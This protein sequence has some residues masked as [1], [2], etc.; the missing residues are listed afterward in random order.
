MWSAFTGLH[1]KGRRLALLA[2]I[3]VRIE[4]LAG[5][6]RQVMKGQELG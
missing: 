3:E 6:I 4:K 1:S 5:T 2:K